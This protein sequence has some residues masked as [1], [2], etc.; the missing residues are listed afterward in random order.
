M[1]QERLSTAQMTETLRKRDQSSTKT[2]RLELSVERCACYDFPTVGAHWRVT[3][4][5]LLDRL[6]VQGVFGSL[7]TELVYAGMMLLFGLLVVFVFFLQVLPPGWSGACS[8]ACSPE[9]D[10]IGPDQT[11]FCSGWPMA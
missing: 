3:M 9:L 7:P 6:I 10:R 4:Q 5:A 11:A 8:H 2:R 1:S